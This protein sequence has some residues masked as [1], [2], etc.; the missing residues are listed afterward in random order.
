M[1][2]AKRKYIKVPMTA[3]LSTLHVKA[4]IMA[5]VKVGSASFVFFQ[6][7]AAVPSKNR[8]PTMSSTDAM[9]V[10]GMLAQKEDMRVESRNNT[11]HTMVDRPERAPAW[12]P[13]HVIK[14]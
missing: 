5:V 14:H 13:I 4:V 7:T 11:P 12:M 6:S 2:T 1:V 3:P 9:P 8:K 10:S